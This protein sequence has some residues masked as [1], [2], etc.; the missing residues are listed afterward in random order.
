MST[1]EDLRHSISSARSELIRHQTRAE[2]AANE[3]ADLESQAKKLGIS[4]DKLVEEAER[5]RGDVEVAVAEVNKE[6]EAV[7]GKERDG[8]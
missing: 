4:S 6:L 8:S 5:I 3:L 7:R 1:I 2:T